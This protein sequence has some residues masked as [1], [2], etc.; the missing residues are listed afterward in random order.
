MK[1]RKVSV[2]ERLRA[3]TEKLA[4]LMTPTAARRE[5]LRRTPRPSH[6]PAGAQRQASADDGLLSLDARPRA[7]LGACG[8]DRRIDFSL[9][10][11]GPH[12]E[13]DRRAQRSA[14]VRTVLRL[15]RR[16]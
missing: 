7:R 2:A 16:P 8:V 1:M 6:L 9:C 14:V 15:C 4:A 13:F 5:P 3:K 11:V 10:Q 12:P